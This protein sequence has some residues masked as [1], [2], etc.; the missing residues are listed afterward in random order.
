MATFLKLHFH[1][2]V[3]KLQ[4]PCQPSKIFNANHITTIKVHWPHGNPFLPKKPAGPLRLR[5]SLTFNNFRFH[6]RP[7][8]QFKPSHRSGRIATMKL[9]IFLFVAM[10]TVANTLPQNWPYRD[11]MEYYGYQNNN[12]GNFYRASNLGGGSSEDDEVEVNVGNNKARQDLKVAGGEFPWEL[13]FF[14]LINFHGNGLKYC[15][16]NKNSQRSI[17][18]R[19]SI[20]RRRRGNRFCQTSY[21]PSEY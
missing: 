6:S 1:A 8:P 2:N 18:I 13:I 21:G 12:R 14:L 5:F 19:R 4:I 7:P 10:A 3:L 15:Y 17:T 20:T 11:N 9:V 16:G